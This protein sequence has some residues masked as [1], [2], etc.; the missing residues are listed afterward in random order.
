M[1]AAPILSAVAFLGPVLVG[2][3]LVFAGLAKALDPSHFVHHLKDLRILPAQLLF[4]AVLAVISLQCGLGTALVLHVWPAGLLPAAAVLLLALAALGY[5]ST[6][7]GRAFDCGCYN[8][9]LTFSPLQ[10]LLLDAGYAALLVLA[11]WWAPADEAR[12]WKISAVFLA[13]VGGGLLAFG[14][15][16]YSARYG[17]PLFELTPLKIG[18]LWNPRWMEDNPGPSANGGEKL[19]VFMGANCSHCKRWIKP[20]N[21]IHWLP[22]FPEVQ[23]V[24]T[25][26]P[27]RLPQFLEESSIHFPVATVK[28]W[29]AARLS[30]GITPTAVLVRD[31][32]IREKW[33]QMMPKEFTDRLRAEIS[34]VAGSSTR[35]AETALPSR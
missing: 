27:E 1:T 13:T 15:S 31:G 30:R 5:W 29:V 34:R 18:R 4:P 19:I 16:H 24:V 26:S 12:L 22:S 28:P 23:G 20:L 7:T 8:G 9:L 25:L 3:V 35:P 17:K 33:I 32:I 11:W 10:S 14:I 21:T 6:A 2:I